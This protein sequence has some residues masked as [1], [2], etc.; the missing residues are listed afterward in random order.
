TY[1]GSSVQ[2][3]TGFD[4]VTGEM[5]EVKGAGSIIAKKKII[6]RK[7]FVPLPYSNHLPDDEKLEDRILRITTGDEAYTF[8]DG[9]ITTIKLRDPAKYNLW[10]KGDLINIIDPVHGWTDDLTITEDIHKGDTE[11]QIESWTPEEGEDFPPHSYLEIDDQYDAANDINDSAIVV[12]RH[13]SF[14]GSSWNVHSGSGNKYTFPTG[15]LPN[16]GIHSADLIDKRL[17]ISKGG[18]ELYYNLNV[19]TA[20]QY[21]KGYTISGDTIIFTEPITQKTAVKCVAQKINKEN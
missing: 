1:L 6:L 18:Q 3:V 17:H 2:Y 12:Q 10:H 19:D 8:R 16:P 20:D 14:V 9:G 21:D 11:I 4:Q 15:V 7:D 5:I 13:D